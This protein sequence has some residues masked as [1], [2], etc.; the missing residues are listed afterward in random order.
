MIKFVPPIYETLADTICLRMPRTGL[1]VLYAV[2]A[3]IEFIISQFKLPAI[4][5][6][7]C[8]SGFG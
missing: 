3:K 5:R 2:Y 1:G 6:V 7:P 8:P 4:F